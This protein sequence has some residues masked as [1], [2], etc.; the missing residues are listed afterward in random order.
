MPVLSRE[1][2]EQIGPL[3]PLLFPSFLVS[4][5]AEQI[6]PPLLTKRFKGDERVCSWGL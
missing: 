3:P 2:A 5:I 6:Y 1:I 4:E